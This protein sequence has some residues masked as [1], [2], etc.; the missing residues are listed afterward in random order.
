MKKYICSVCGYVYDEATTGIKW[1]NLP[2]D[3]VCPLCGATKQEFVE[4]QDDNQ[5]SEQDLAVGMDNLGELRE[6]SFGELSALWSNLSRGCK[7]QYRE[8]EADLFNTLSGYYKSKTESPT[9]RSIEDLL[10]LVQQDLSSN[11]LRANSVA[12]Q[13]ADRGALRSLKWGENVTKILNSLLSRYK[14][15]G[16]TFLE[17]TNLYICE[18]CGFIYTGDE[19]PDICPVCKVPKLKITQVQ[20]GQENAR[21]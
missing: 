16:D 2:G 20:R 18:M 9:Q 19:A 11:Y 7:Q 13:E 14:Q 12:A 8:E 1:D 10:A 5:D 4:H 17:N 15:Q 21:S 3:W 6:L